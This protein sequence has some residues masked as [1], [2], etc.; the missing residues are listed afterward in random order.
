MSGVAHERLDLVFYGIHVDVTDHD[1]RLIIGAVPLVVEVSAKF[2]LQPNVKY[3]AF[4][5]SKTD[6]SV[7]SSIV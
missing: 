6:A 4:F 7:I 5:P 2:N 1:D 3:T